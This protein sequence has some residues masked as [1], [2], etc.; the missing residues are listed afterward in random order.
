MHSLS[1]RVAST[2]FH[3]KL[4]SRTLQVSHNTVSRW[5]DILQTL[6]VCYR[7]SPFGS[8]SKIRAVR[9]GKKAISL[10]LGASK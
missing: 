10:G 4:K 7:I 1:D 8:S 9:K 5:L 6:Y 3:R 2:S